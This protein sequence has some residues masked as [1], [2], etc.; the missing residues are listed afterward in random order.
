[1]K[2]KVPDKN[3]PWW[4]CSP[5]VL[6]TARFYPICSCLFLTYQD[7]RA[8]HERVTISKL[9][10]EHLKMPWVEKCRTE[11]THALTVAPLELTFEFIFLLE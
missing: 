1:M 11:V 6:Q 2:S 4:S 9:A 10:K 5:I 8:S 3:M 7:V